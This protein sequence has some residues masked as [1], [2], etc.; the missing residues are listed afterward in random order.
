MNIKAKARKQ[1]Q[2]IIDRAA[3]SQLQQVELPKEGWIASARKALGLSAAQLA[4]A[5]GKS[6]ANIV[7]VERSEQDGRANLRTIKTMAEAM[8]CKLVYAIIPA[9]GSVEGIIE[10]QARKKA[11]ALVNQANIH[12]ALERQSLGN[13]AV[14]DEVIRVTRE[15]MEKSPFD[16]W[17]DE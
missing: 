3:A 17:D 16:L 15:I 10:Q 11:E 1:Y 5:L 4:R 14:E 13:K 2:A 12:M 8:G 9:S 6:R 7:A